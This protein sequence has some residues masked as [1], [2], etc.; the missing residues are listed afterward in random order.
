M[1]RSIQ[2]GKYFICENVT[3]QIFIKTSHSIYTYKS[4]KK[5]DS[6]LS[7]PNKNE[8]LKYSVNNDDDNN[9]NNKE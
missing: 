3:E 9:N 7:F 1:F 5:S 6:S 2:K 4:I 8:Y